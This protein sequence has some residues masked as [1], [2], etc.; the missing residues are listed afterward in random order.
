MSDHARVHALVRA[1]MSAM[2]SPASFRSSVTRARYSHLSLQHTEFPSVDGAGATCF[3]LDRVERRYLLCGTVDGGVHVYDTES[4]SMA[5]DGDDAVRTQAL[6]CAIPGGG[7]RATQ[8]RAA[9]PSTS[10]VFISDVTAHAYATSCAKW[11]PSDTGMF[12]T[13]GF[14]AAVKCWDANSLLEASALELEAKCHALALSSISTS[15]ALV[16]IGT[17]DA[18]VRLWD[19]G[20]NVIA[21]T[22][23]GH[24]GSVRAIDWALSSEYQLATGGA[25]GDVRV[26]DIRRAGAFMILDRHNTQQTAHVEGI[27]DAMYAGSSGTTVGAGPK[28]A[29]RKMADSIPDH[30][31]SDAARRCSSSSYSGRGHARSGVKRTRDGGWGGWGV[32]FRPKNG[33][34]PDASASKHVPTRDG[35]S[36]VAASA[37]EGQVT[38]LKVTPCGLFLI[39]TGVDAR[40]RRWD[41]TTGLNTYAPYDELGPIPT[42][43][44][45]Q[46]AISGDGERLF[47]PCGTGDVKIF[48]THTAVLHTTLKGHLDEAFACAHKDGG[49]AALFTLGKDRNILVWEP[50]RACA[51]ARVH[52]DGVID[53]DAWSDDDADGDTGTAGIR[54][55]PN[56]RFASR[57]LGYRSIRR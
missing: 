1:R 10:S 18:V 38:G 36:S 22:L 19:P 57:G 14:D 29:S 32:G 16:A 28:P 11:L 12:F 43:N 53:G 52:G 40:V 24:R 54:A 50:P 6:V 41:L 44:T 7:A 4:T 3:D 42:S 8:S 21:H 25:E 33:A 45:C 37:H 2:I 27:K 31:R 56:S 23:S 47:V 13:C 9:S 20:A 34:R 51:D 35:Y 49:S 5:S 26:W 30:L 17:D 55:D 39:S 48:N 15:H 46:P